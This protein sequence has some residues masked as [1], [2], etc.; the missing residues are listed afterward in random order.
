MIYTFFIF[1]IFKSMFLES[2][3]LETSNHKWYILKEK[4]ILKKY[5]SITNRFDCFHKYFKYLPFFLSFSF[6]SSASLSPLQKKR[7]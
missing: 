1:K 4:E 5:K 3:F 6:L 2:D 7:K